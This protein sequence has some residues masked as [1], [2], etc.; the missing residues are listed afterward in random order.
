MFFR[1]GGVGG[2]VGGGVA[3]GCDQRG[4]VVVC[5]AGGLRYF[6]LAG[7]VGGRV[8]GSGAL[9]A[10]S[11][12]RGCVRGWGMMRGEVCGM[13]GRRGGGWS[14][15]AAG[16]WASV[17]RG[18]YQVGCVRPF[19][20]ALAV[21]WAAGGVGLRAA[22]RRR[23]AKRYFGEGDVGSPSGGVKR[24]CRG[25]M[26]GKEIE[27]GEVARK[28]GDRGTRSPLRVLFVNRTEPGMVAEGASASF[29]GRLAK[30]RRGCCAGRGMMRGDGLSVVGR[31]GRGGGGG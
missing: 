8:A 18:G 7:F 17:G 27:M 2:F 9:A 12:R 11:V 4:G 15:R 24:K 16:G 10:L 25:C 28:D 26:I 29:R 1:V 30:R 13:F 23:A 3:S 14:S 21:R 22:G 5:G 31:A 20:L 6:G 19:F